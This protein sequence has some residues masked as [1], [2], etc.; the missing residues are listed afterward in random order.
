MDWIIN[1]RLLSNPMNWVSIGV[2][3]I[4]VLVAY[5]AI[6]SRVAA[7]STVAVES[8]DNP[9]AALAPEK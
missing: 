3:L 4:L 2:M 1:T 6:R 9:A 5:I 8:P 7:S